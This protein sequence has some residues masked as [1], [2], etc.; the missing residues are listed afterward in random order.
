MIKKIIL[1]TGNLHKAEEIISLLKDLNIEIIPMTHFPKYL[2][3]I[4]DGKSLEEN[5]AKKATKASKFFKEWTIADDSGLEVDY[6]DGAPGIYSARYAGEK[7]TYHDNN[8]KLLAALDGV[9]EEKRTAKFKTVIALSSPDGKICLAKG[10]IFG[11]IANRV[12]GANGF[13]YDSIFYVPEYGKTF[14]ELSFELKNSI[15][16]RAKASQKIRK[17]VVDL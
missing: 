1:A 17:I 10:E 8:K 14:S 5:A 2:K 7:C 4:E 13:G 15:S 6:L 16:H 11:T 9:S 3:A 12:A